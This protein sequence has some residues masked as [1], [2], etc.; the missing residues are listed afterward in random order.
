MRSRQIDP[1]MTNALKYTYNRNDNDENLR[2]AAEVDYEIANIMTTS[3]N[4]IAYAENII[5]ALN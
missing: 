3:E 5:R 4:R 2:R 1:I